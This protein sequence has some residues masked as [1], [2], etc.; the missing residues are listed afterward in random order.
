[1]KKV[2]LGVAVSLD[3]SMEGP[4]SEYDWCPTPSKKEMDDFMGNIDSIFF[5]RK[6][7]DLVG[8]SAFP[9]KEL[10]VFS[11]S[12][13]EVDGNLVSGN[14][15]SHVKE[16]KNKPVK[17][18]WLYG[19]ASLTTTFINEG[20][21]DRMWFGIVPTLLGEGKPLFSGIKQRTHEATSKDGCLSLSL[22]YENKTK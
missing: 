5:G 6:S 9:G 11:N 17:D 18:I 3:G 16:I 20:L 12:L 8:P 4:N 15:A 10:Y 1:M 13:E 19:G 21:I 2:I 7:F 22:G 14:I